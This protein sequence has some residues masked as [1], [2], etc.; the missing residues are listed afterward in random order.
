MESRPTIKIVGP[1]MSI[2]MILGAVFITLKL[3]HVIDWSWWLV[4][5]PIYLPLGL[6]L[7][8]ALIFCAI[9]SIGILAIN[10]KGTASDR[11]M[12][13]YTRGYIK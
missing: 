8:F 9:V 5:M 1:N 12:R 2:F 10:G 7:V 11:S 4:L 13:R 3:C 6:F